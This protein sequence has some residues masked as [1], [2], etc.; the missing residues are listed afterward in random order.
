MAWFEQ[1][2][3]R[4][5]TACPF[6]ATRSSPPL[7]RDEIVERNIAPAVPLTP[8]AVPPREAIEHTMIES[9]MVMIGEIMLI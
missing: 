3:Q 9:I 6:Q 7:E 8:S 2:A 5:T 1:H 4:P